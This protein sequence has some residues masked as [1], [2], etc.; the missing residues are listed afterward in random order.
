MHQKKKCLKN[1]RLCG[2]PNKMQLVELNT[3][4]GGNVMKC[5]ICS[6]PVEP[7]NNEQDVCPNCAPAVDDLMN[8]RGDDEDE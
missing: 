1:K 7:E 4:R 5:I 8:G 2:M 3:I 6:R